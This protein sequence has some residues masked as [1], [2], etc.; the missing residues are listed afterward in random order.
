M[1]DLMPACN[2]LLSEA[3]EVFVQHVH[4]RQAL[5][6]HTAGCRIDA[7][8]NSWRAEPL[9]RPRWQATAR[10]QAMPAYMLSR[11]SSLHTAQ[12][13]R[14]RSKRWRPGCAERWASPCLKP[15]QTGRHPTGR[16][17]CLSKLARRRPAA[18]LLHPNPNEALQVAC[19]AL[20]TACVL[21]SCS[22]SADDLEAFC[23]TA[24]LKAMV[25]L[26]QAAH[27]TSNS[28]ARKQT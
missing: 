2:G 27:I 12:Q 22:Q 20:Q 9:Q 24:C 7:G 15:A 10:R 23:K 1:C 17:L 8:L 5:L 26:L 16:S 18:G 13:R 28:V 6:Q 3:P 25:K 11:L 4:V 21:L 14:R 19:L